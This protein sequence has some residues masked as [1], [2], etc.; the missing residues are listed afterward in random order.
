MSRKRNE[1]QPQP[2]RDAAARLGATL[3]RIDYSEE[4]IVELLGED[5]PAADLADVPVH[6][7]RLRRRPCGLAT[8]TRLLL[9]QLPVSVADAVEALGRDGVD[10]L[11]ALQLARAEDGGLR[12]RARLVPAEGLLLSFDRFARG[13]GDPVGYVASYTPTASWLAALTPRR[14]V[15]RALDVGTGNGVQALLAAR[16]ADHVVA[17]DVNARALAFTEINAALNGF[18]NVETRLGSLF[19]P[20]QGERFDLIACNAPYVVSPESRW[21][22]RD[23][24]LPADELSERVV[25]QAAASLADDG[26]AALLVSWVAETEEDPDVRLDG[27]LDGCG[28]DAWALGLHGSEPLDHAA[29]W[30]EHLEGEALAAALDEWTAYFDSLGIGWIS[31][32]AVL[33]HRRDGAAHI[34]RADPAEPD[35]LEFAGEQVERVFASYARLAALAG[36]SD[37]L[38]G[39]PA[40]AK[41]VLVEHRRESGSRDAD[42][43]LVLDEGTYDEYELDPDV[44]EVVALLD[45]SL[46]LG[47]AVERVSKAFELDRR[48]ASE[49]RADSLHEVRDLLEL[50]FAEL[51]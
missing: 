13:A 2:D 38:D 50:G 17:T 30:N 21:Q 3:R 7:R 22:Y 25:R 49:L 33:L 44:A 19:E 24:G 23:G 4:T 45:G 11:L 31:E 10:A 8:A 5:G 15:S 35:D 18:D 41:S 9:L 48:E 37:L 14:R 26:L 12:P 20:V 16:H 40:L 1:P 6:E 28:C 29:G 46:T 34:F 32:G 42:T 47:R 43:W 36:E 27:W 51:R 39:T